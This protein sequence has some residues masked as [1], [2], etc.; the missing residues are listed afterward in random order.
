MLWF[1]VQSLDLLNVLHEALFLLNLYGHQAVCVCVC[2][3]VCT[4]AVIN[5]QSG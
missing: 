3:C 4:A 2:V 1:L 5:T